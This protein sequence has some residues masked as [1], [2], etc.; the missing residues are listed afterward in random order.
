MTKMSSLS[1]IMDGYQYKHKIL[2]LLVLI[3]P[4]EKLL[5]VCH[6]FER[7]WPAR[8]TRQNFVPSPE[9]LNMRRNDP[10][11]EELIEEEVAPVT[12]H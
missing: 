10:D 9:N 6:S 2:P 4:I 7:L 3:N 1:Q 11:D 5:R 12:S 8:E